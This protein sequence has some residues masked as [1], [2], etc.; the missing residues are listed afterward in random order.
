M[1]GSGIS[2]I[3]GGALGAAIAASTAAKTQLDTLTEQAGSGYVSDSYAGLGASAQTALSL[4]PQIAQLTAQ[5]SA[6]GAVTSR[7]G[8]T[9]TALTQI[10]SIA[11]NF[12]AQLANLNGVSPSEVD[13]VAADARSAL[14]QVASLL[15]STDGG[16]YVFGGTDSTNP[17]VPNPDAIL[18]SG[19]YTQTGAAVAGLGANGAA[20]TA[21]STLA[22]A[23]SDAAGTTPF[24][25]P[26]GQA[27]TLTLANGADGGGAAV[28][29]GLLANANTLAVSDGTSTTGSYTRDILRGLATIANL[30][31][32]Q[33]NDAGFGALVLDT[34]ASLTGA[35]KALNVEGGVL[36]DTQASLQSQQTQASDTSTALTGQLSS[37]EDVDMAKTLSSL[38]AVQTQLSAS[39]KLISEVSSLSLVKYL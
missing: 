29:V 18:T 8:V 21:A 6:I 32:S 34:Q 15:D 37:V 17:P 5:Q 2:A 4:Q 20:A 13:S 16:Q 38:S 12:R 26:P 35:V 23:S 25:G 11:S 19:F 27:P 28:Q 1:S 3:T 22:V 36:G 30:S 9:Q 33:V 7:L 24:S 10:D 14:Q 39:Y 31:S